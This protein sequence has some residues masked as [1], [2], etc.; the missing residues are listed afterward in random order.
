M[1]YPSV[2]KFIFVMLLTSSLQTRSYVHN[3]LFWHLSD[4]HVDLDYT[5]HG[6]KGLLGDLNCDSPLTLWISALNATREVVSTRPDFVIFS[7]DSVSHTILT[8]KSFERTM[9]EVV[10]ALKAVFPP[11]QNDSVPVILSL[12]NHD[13]FPDNTMSVADGDP[14]R[15]FWCT[16]LGSSPNLWGGWIAD[17]AEADSSHFSDGCYYSRIVRVGNQTSLRII[18]L[19]GLI[20]A[21]RNSLGNASLTD[22]LG[23]FD[24][25]TNQLQSARQ[26]M[27]KVLL[28]M[29]FPLGAPENSPVYFRHLH[30]VYNERFLEILSE[31]SDV[32]ALGLFGHQHTDTFRVL[33][34]P[35][36]GAS[37]NGSKLPL[38]FAPSISPFHFQDLGGFRPRIRI[39]N[40]S[41]STPD[42]PAL[43]SSS[44]EILDFRQYYINL[45]LNERS[46]WSLEYMPTMAYNLSNLSG[47]SMKD[48][49]DK[50]ESNQKLWNSYWNHELGLGMPHDSG[51]CPEIKSR[52]HCG[53]MCPLRHIH[54]P[55]LD[56]CLSECEKVGDLLVAPQKLEDNWNTVPIVVLVILA[57]SGILIGVVLFVNRELCRRKARSRRFR[58][59][60]EFIEEKYRRRGPCLTG[61]HQPD[62][63]NITVK[64]SP[65]AE[66]GLRLG[67]GF[68]SEELKSLNVKEM[69]DG[70]YD[71]DASGVD[72]D[73]TPRIP[74]GAEDFCSVN[75]SPFQGLMQPQ[76]LPLYSPQQKKQ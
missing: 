66:D 51:S 63:N 55:S 57:F 75:S 61:Y 52:R 76:S 8:R 46:S 20:Y 28:V 15:R 69:E 22:P 17:D 25:L 18:S 13:V 27:E 26:K 14:T 11:Y 65:L 47:G 5:N 16:R 21:R 29:H 59:R 31:F 4:V 54:F 44:L 72:E 37:R 19:N 34:V 40:Y 58:R 62:L 74:T 73:D 70:T 42:A 39:F 6:C 2:L 38:F 32:I 1:E 67:N 71:A 45:S 36:Q 9:E 35:S 3:G 68:G 41:M 53:H 30:D 56:E 64:R 50:F 49:L 7:G 33:E 10:S 24:W 43:L 23:Q 60:I 12:G 48:L